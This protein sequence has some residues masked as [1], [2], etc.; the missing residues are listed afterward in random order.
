MSN[1]RSITRIE[2]GQFALIMG[3]TY[4]LIGIII[5]VLMYLFTSM[6]PMPAPFGS[7]AR[8]IGVIFIPI[9]Y[10]IIGYICGFIGAMIYNLV[11]GTVGGIKV[12]VSD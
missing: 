5:G 12:T 8:G 7:A 11:A 9:V 6:I 1:I 10:G 4:V 2:P 3:V